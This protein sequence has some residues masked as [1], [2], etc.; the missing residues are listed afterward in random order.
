MFGPTLRKHLT[1]TSAA[2]ALP[3]IN[4]LDIMGNAYEV[5]HLGP[6]GIK[7]IRMVRSETRQVNASH[8]GV[9]DP[10]A[11]KESENAGVSIFA[12]PQAHKDKDG[13]IYTR[14]VNVKT[15]REEFIP[16]SELE[17]KVIAFPAQEIS[18]DVEVLYQGRV[19]RLPASKVEYQYKNPEDLHTYQTNL[20]P[21]LNSI[22]GNRAVMA[23]KHLLHSLPLKYREQPLVQSGMRSGPYDTVEQQVASLILPRAK[24]DGEVKKVTEDTVHIKGKGKDESQIDHFETNFPLNQKTYLHTELDVKPGDKVKAGQILGDSIYTKDKALAIGTNL[25]VAYVS[26]KGLNINDGAVISES[27]AKKLTSLHMNK[28]IYDIDESHAVGKSNFTVKFPNKFNINQLQSIGDDGVVK[29]GS[30]IHE[31]DP[32]ILGVERTE[33][34]A[35][36]S[37]LGNI[38]K[39]LFR[40]YRED[41]IVWSNAFEGEVTDVFTSPHRIVVLIKSEQPAT[42]GDKISQRSAGKGVITAIVK[43]NDMFKNEAG[44]TI[45]VLYS[46]TGIVSRQNPAQILETSLA[47][48]AKKIGKPIVV[49][50]FDHVDNH[51]F[52]MDMMKKHGVK[53]KENIFDPQTGRMIPNIMTGPQ[54]VLKQAN[55]VDTGFSARNFGQYDANEIPSRGGDGGAKQIGMLDINSLLSHNSRNILKEVS[56]IKGTKN[57]DFWSAYQRGLPLPTPKVPFA[58]NKLL[59]MMTA[60]GVKLNKED[61]RLIAAPL[62]NRDILGMSKGKI[63]SPYTVRA[64]DLRPETDG[65][66][67]PSVTGGATGNHWSHIELAHPVINPLMKDPV[68]VLLGKSDTSLNQMIINDG[69]DAIRKQLSKIDVDKRIEELNKTIPTLKYNELD[70]AIKEIKYLKALK[71]HDLKP[72][73]AYILDHIPVLPPIMRPITRLAGTQDLQ[74]SAAN[75]MYADVI[76]TNNAYNT[77]AD[78]LEKKDLGD[79]RLTLQQSVEALVGTSESPNIKLRKQGIKGILNTISGDIPKSGFF[80]AKVLSKPQDLAGRAVINPDPNLA[81]DQVG[82]PEQMLWVL[83]KPMIIRRLVQKGYS[84]LKAKELIEQKSPIARNEMLVETKERP[85]LINR[86]P[87]LHK[88]NIQGAYAIPTQNKVLT[89]SPFIEHGVGGDFDGDAMQVHVPVSAKAVE[90]ARRMTLPNML[91]ADKTRDGN[92]IAKPELDTNYGLFRGVNAQGTG[93]THTLS[94]PEEVKNAYKRGDIKLTDKVKIGK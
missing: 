67:D 94:T 57:M 28:F 93:A 51:A 23:G 66:F 69:V 75:R 46:P 18:G 4:S 47:K 62:T 16:V 70:K 73:E 71:A 45:D 32:L 84:A 76:H 21:F 77:V 41:A 9:M 83:Y 82:V 2:S 86:A 30:K 60:S 34:T 52:V 89:I 64:K 53:D 10:I 58:Y 43:D 39:K 11:T 6:G 25:N 8:M 79:L 85:M 24:I 74:V 37:L 31:G 80:Q 12:T 22:S 72:H 38:H 29:K 59:G 92:L 26:Y 44:E 54:F 88:Y 1:T 78:K 19:Q 40:P 3:Q 87:D 27:A 48:V 35:E 15:K 49:N 68:K 50:N 13:N 36:Q 90:E 7:D 61:N 33:L 14:V 63:T 5:T 17:S 55:Q 81:M 91:F 65:L 20:I 56:T 42:I